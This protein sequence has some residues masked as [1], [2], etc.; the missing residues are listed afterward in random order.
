MILNRWKIE[1][2][3]VCD[4]LFDLPLVD[5]NPKNKV[6]IQLRS[7]K[8]LTDE[9]LQNL[10]KEVAEKFSDKEIE[11]F[12][13]QDTLDLKTC[14]KFEDYLKKIN[15]NIKTE[16]LY[17]QTSQQIVERLAQLQ[18]LIAMRFHACL[19]AVRYGVKTLALSY[20]VKVDKFAEE[21]QIPYV[22]MKEYDFKKPIEAM[23]NLS[24]Q[25]LL[26]FAKTKRFD[27][28]KIEKLL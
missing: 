14:K 1:A 10:A 13:F 8:T 19:I 2:D 5:Y 7:F 4:P 3:L 17:N 11:I 6:G 9:F 12:S 18:Y 15:K 24:S 23:Q 16:I 20:D 22:Q 21:A 28:D 26:E 27:W 25:D